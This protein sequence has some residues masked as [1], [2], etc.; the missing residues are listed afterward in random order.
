MEKLIR[1]RI[2]IFIIFYC[3][4]SFS[5]QNDDTS[6]T[7][8]GNWRYAET[9]QGHTKPDSTFVIRLHKTTSNRLEG[10][11][12]FI[13][14]EGIRLDC[15]PEGQQQNLKGS[16]SPDGQHVRIDFFSFFGAKNGVA[17][18]SINDGKLTWKV[19][20]LPKGGFFYGPLNVVLTKDN[21]NT[22]SRRVIVERA[23]LFRDP[24]GA[25]PPKS[26]LIEGDKVELVKLSDNLKFWK[27]KYALTNGQVIERW[28]D[29]EA[30]D[31]CP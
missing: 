20:K 22:R 11:Y 26:Y 3:G 17:D 16:L 2:A 6:S 24:T 9:N 15:D 23:Y 18:I 21:G 31:S 29:C 10:S 13:T 12:C 4:A 5:Q 1:C 28:I 14:Q 25:T 7:I 19:V 8:F 30:I 27:V